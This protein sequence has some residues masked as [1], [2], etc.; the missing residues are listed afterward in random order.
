MGLQATRSGSDCGFLSD[1]RLWVQIG[2][3]N[4]YYRRTS[5]S[6][7]PSTWWRH[8]ALRRG[9]EPGAGA[10][11][12]GLCPPLL[13]KPSQKAYVRFL[14]PVCARDADCRSRRD[15]SPNDTAALIVALTRLANEK[16]SG[17]KR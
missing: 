17:G 12:S 6:R 9:R 4:R 10:F 16:P 15:E 3:R 2:A 11:H 8:E 13:E 1:L 14:Q 7:L 5:P